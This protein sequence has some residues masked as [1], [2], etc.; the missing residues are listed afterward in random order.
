MSQS[1]A[2]KG[3]AARF[4]EYM[5][6][7]KPDLFFKI[8]RNTIP[9]FGNTK[10][11]PVFITRF[12]DVQE[13]LT[14]P[15]VFRVMYAPMMD[16]SVGPFM[17][18]RDGTTINQRDKGIMR[19]LIQR[20]DIPK[21]KA[22]SAKLADQAVSSQLDKKQIEVVNTVSRWVPVRLTCEYFGF[23]GPNDESMFRWSR[24]TQ[25]DMFHN[26]DN[27]PQV[28]QE[29]IEAGAQMK[30]FLTELLP[31]RRQEIG[32]NPDLDDIL[33]RL[34]KSRFDDSIKFDESR[35][36]TN[37]MG[38]LVGGIETTSQAVVQILE[39]LFKRPEIL[40][41]AKKLA[42]NDDD[43]QLY[44]YCWE[45][46]RFNPINPFVMRQ[47]AKDYKIASG[48]WRS[49]TIKA[50][51][52]VLVSGRSAMR[53][54]RQVPCANDFCIDRPDYHYMHMGYGEHTCLGDMVGRIEITQMV[55]RL[56]LLPNVRPVSEIDFEGGPFP[57]R[58]VIAFD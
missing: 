23:T 28:H 13:A 26:Q 33:S 39:Q 14:R 45:A 51:A 11:G 9:V 21:I 31:K 41:Q 15:E 47:C 4:I 5:L 2:K 40:E 38:T 37:I 53:D 3:L 49:K 46:L 52:V 57:E 10:T 44:Q 42:A 17:L 29:N 50:G 8:L 22:I 19:S 18:G 25:Y 30:D 48:S 32:D 36:M 1:S 34:L 55:K 7:Q 12:N 43:K 6:T 56:L 35:I 54:G 24:A 16:P 20:E 58:Y 27:D